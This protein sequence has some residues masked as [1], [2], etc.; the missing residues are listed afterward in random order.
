MRGDESMAEALQASLE[1]HARKLKK[2]LRKAEQGDANAIHHGRTT[3]RRLREGLVVMGRT[4]FDPA[5]TG[6]LEDALHRIE[7]AL[8]PTRDDDVLLADLDD[9]LAQ[10][11]RD[12]GCALLPLREHLAGVRA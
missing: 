7:Q 11:G 9:W 3:L 4:L 1:P 10:A 6:E 2:R 8:G 12:S 5:T